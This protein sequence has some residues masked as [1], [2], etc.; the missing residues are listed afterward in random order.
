[1]YQFSFCQVTIF[2]GGEEECRQVRIFNAG[3]PQ[4]LSRVDLARCVLKARGYSPICEGIS[5][6]QSCSRATIHHAVIYF[7]VGAYLSSSQSKTARGKKQNQCPERLLIWGIHLPWTYQW[8]VGSQKRQ[9][10][11]YLRQQTSSQSLHLALL[12]TKP[13]LALLF[14]LVQ[15]LHQ[16]FYNYYSYSYHLQARISLEILIL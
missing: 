14:L 12:S 7:L 3:G 8:I 10:D 11:A 1:M 6:P 2:N 9:P 5:F 16:I 13:T 4:K 15:M